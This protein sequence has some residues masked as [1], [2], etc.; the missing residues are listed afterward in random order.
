MHGAEP[1]PVKVCRRWVD[2]VELKDLTGPNELA[3]CDVPVPHACA[4]SPLGQAEARLARSQ[5]LFGPLALRDVGEDADG[6]GR[7][8]LAVE[9][10]LAA[11]QQPTD[12]AV[13][14]KRAVLRL[15]EALAAC[16]DVPTDRLKPLALAW[17]VA[18]PHLV[19]SWFGVLWE[20]QEPVKLGRANHGFGPQ[21]DL[22]DGHAS[23]VDRQPQPLGRVS[24]GGLKAPP[25]GDVLKRADVTQR[26]NHAAALAEDRAAMGQ[27]PAQR[28]VRAQDAVLE[29][30]LGP[31]RRIE[32]APGLGRGERVVL[33]M[34]DVAH[35]LE[36]HL[37][38]R[39]EAAD[40][41]GER[42][43]GHPVGREVP[44]PDADLSR[45]G[46]EVEA[47]LA[48]AKRVRLRPAP[49]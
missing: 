25:L 24:L 29:G 31:D 36:A 39:G 23:G 48:L 44:V 28:A 41:L 40:R 10:K 18:G 13:R 30:A 43:I 3:R 20:A 16:E 19:E 47:R 7:S 49:P 2:A 46:R 11:Q 26:L 8:T 33:R 42:R 4:C 9:Q 45:G 22:P 21:I 27:H 15:H 38:V 34:D 6:S 17:I 14:P 37:L 1:S 35:V 32:R 5:T 12:R